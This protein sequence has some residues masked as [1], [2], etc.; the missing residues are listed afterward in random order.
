MTNDKIPFGD[1]KRQHEL[2]RSELEQAF[3]KNLASGWFILGKELEKFE[4]DFAGYCGRKYGIGVGN[5]TDAIFLT[6]KAQGIRE[7][8]EV[9]TVANTAIPTCSAIVA[10]GAK[11]VLVD[12]KKDYLMD[13]SK[14]GRAITP[15]TKA[16]IPVHLYG[17]TCNMETT[18]KIAE[19]HHLRIIEDC[20]QAHGAKQL[21]QRTPIKGTGCFSF[22]PSKNLGAMG[23]GGIIVTDDKELAEKLRLIRNYGQPQTYVSTEPGYNSRLDE[24]QAAILGIKLKHLEVWN[25]RRREIAHIY[26]SLLEGLV[27]TPKENTGNSH[28]YHLYVIKTQKRDDLKDYLRT[29]GIDTKV[30][31]PVPI[32][33]QPGFASLGYKPGDFPNSEKYSQEILSLPMFPELRDEEVVRICEEVKNWR[34]TKK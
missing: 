30:H 29:R 31:Y 18:L 22:Y 2:L 12:T 19:A 33:L 13:T 11:L 34:L 8:D 5:A 6:L 26:N 14:I 25:A 21:G 20:A 3:S 10:S 16:I 27:E 24:L 7:G 32:H 28:V 15:E 9:I 23:D 4:E 17:Q 1:L